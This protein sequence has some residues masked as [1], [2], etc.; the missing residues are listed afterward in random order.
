MSE[1]KSFVGNDFFDLAVK[2]VNQTNQ[3]IFVTGKAGTGKTTF[4]KYIRE[5]CS[6]RMAIAAPTGVAA[7]NAGGMTL[8]SLFWLPFGAYAEKHEVQWDGGNHLVNNRTTLFGSLKLTRQRRRLIQELELLVID[9]ISMVRAD[10]LDAIDT[11]LKSVRK[12][13]RPFGGLQMVLI[14]DLLQ[15]PPVVKEN[16]WQIL[17]NYY[18]SPYFF[19]ANVILQNPLV[20]IEFQ[21]IYRQS[22]T[23]FIEIL[24][25][26]RS[27][28]IQKS[29][30]DLLNEYWDPDFTPTEKDNYITLTSHNRL[31]EKINQEA[32]SALSTPLQELKAAVSKDFPE[33]LFPVEMT[34][35]LKE[36]AQVMFIK[37]DSGED[38][39][40]YNGKI[41]YIKKIN[42]LEKTV[43]VAFTN[44]DED[45]EVR[46]ETWENTKYKYDEK[47]G[48]IESEVIGTFSQYPLRLAWA[49]TIHKSQGL[50]FERAVVDAGTSFAA[51]QVYVAL[52]RLTS[53]EG[54]KLKSK[55][56]PHSI[57]VDQRV[58][59]YLNQLENMEELNQYLIQAQKKHLQEILI[60]IFNW[61]GLH[62][63]FKELQEGVLK[64][65]I[66]SKAE[67]VRFLNEIDAEILKIN[68]I[69]NKFMTQLYAIFREVEN[70]NY[71][72]LM[73]R[74]RAAVE[75]FDPKVNQLIVDLNEH[76]QEFKIKKAP[77][78]I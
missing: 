22:D 57:H 3:N 47:E 11:I 51:G 74:V 7:I 72:L 41:G 44:G 60:H 31:A 49:I 24:N 48:K 52:S 54:L 28:R 73:S 68:E 2:F 34:L 16:E 62:A 27:N 78:N 43:T 63:T 37:N 50:T 1:S 19:H 4:L 67:A 66:P 13:Q 18:Q 77:K 5:K 76:I 53:L 35:Q 75:W 17:K 33:S 8:H 71:N 65:K 56:N 42:N 9:E 30:L 59:S 38:R 58:A 10:T 23:Q 70:I 64:M 6:K 25:S 46:R 15:L 12:D 26:I 55:I 45:V 14:G 32:L 61:S 29:E 21:T 69:A 20:N 39:K 36:G 40:F